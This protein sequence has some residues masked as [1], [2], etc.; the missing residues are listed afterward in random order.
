M[1]VA[2]PTTKRWTREEYYRLAEQGYFRGQ[3]V[4]LIEGEIVETPPQKNQHAVAL[5]LGL[6][7]LEAAFGSNAWVRPQLPLRL[8]ESEPEPDLA[9]V[10]GSPRDYA[11][12]DHPTT[13][14][15][16]VE[17]S[18]TT[19]SFD[20]RRKSIIYARAGI[21]DYW[22]INLPRLKLEVRRKPQLDSGEWGYT[23]TQI[24]DIADSM[25]PLAAPQVAIVVADL[26]P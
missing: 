20:Q 26:L 25:A 18:D 1:A 8:E 4:E 7:V 10:A 11:G 16:V 12:K 5:G 24:F 9:V 19:L 2:E 23:S 21:E 3:R 6:R 14:L 22:I 17:I 15:L 13:A